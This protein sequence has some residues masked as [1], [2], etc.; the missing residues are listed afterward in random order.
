MKAGVWI[1]RQL[2]ETWIDFSWSK[3]WNPVTVR[4]MLG[5]PYSR[6]SQRSYSASASLVKYVKYVDENLD[7]FKEKKTR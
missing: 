4:V 5:S 3:R 7:L 1:C 6:I 2:L